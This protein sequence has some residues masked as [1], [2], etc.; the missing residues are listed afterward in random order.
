MWFHYARLLLFIMRNLHYDC[1]APIIPSVYVAFP[2]IYFTF[3]HLIRDRVCSDSMLMR[4]QNYLEEKLDIFGL[5][6]GE[7]MLEKLASDSAVIPVFLEVTP[8]ANLSTVYTVEI[9]VP[10]GITNCS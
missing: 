3:V 9:S 8:M 6:F 10:S 7:C 4:I 5:L 1:G 2:S